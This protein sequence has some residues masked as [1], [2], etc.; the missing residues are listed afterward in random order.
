MTTETLYQVAQT[1]LYEIG[2]GND[3]SICVRRLS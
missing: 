1:D 3:K 2:L